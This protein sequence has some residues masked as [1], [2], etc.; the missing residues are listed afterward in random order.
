MLLFYISFYILNI[1]FFRD[2]KIKFLIFF[3]KIKS[4]GITYAHVPKTLSVGN[5]HTMASRLYGVNICICLT[6]SLL[7]QSVSLLHC[8]KIIRYTLAFRS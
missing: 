3:K 8:L 4:K 1:I 6:T 2:I 7:D 5:G